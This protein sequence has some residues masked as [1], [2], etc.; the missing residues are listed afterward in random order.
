MRNGYGRTRVWGVVGAVAVL[1]LGGCD[2]PS[3][4]AEPSPK[5]FVFQTQTSIGLVRG[6]TVALQLKRVA[7]SLT[8]PVSLTRDGRHIYSAGDSA[9]TVADTASL[10]EQEIDCGGTCI[11][12]LPPLAPLGDG[13]VG[14]F[15]LVATTNPSQDGKTTTAV[16][17]GIDLNASEHHVENLGSIPLAVP[18]PAQ[19]NVAPY[20]FFLDAAQGVYVFLQAV[21]YRPT[22][23]WELAQTLYI[24]RPGSAPMSLGDYAFPSESDVWGVV[25]PD[26]K[27]LAVGSYSAAESATACSS[28][29]VDLFDTATGERTTIHPDTPAEGEVQYRVRRAWWGA[30][31]SLYVN[32]QQRQCDQNAAWSPPV[33]W[34]YTN[35]RWDRVSTPGPALFALNLGDGETAVVEPKGLNSGI[36]YLI[37][38]GGNRTQIAE[39]VTAIADIRQR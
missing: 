19:S 33:V 1:L 17:K 8:G 39:G 16:V 29:G 32:Y 27:R 12:F 26:R 36:L 30:D 2:K 25:S 5:T 14:G 6:S 24:V 4:P 15:D 7:G 21:V 18:Q 11:G 35:G 9:I 10:V 38:K 13:V 23:P 20:T 34:A 3:R 22:R 37:D 28:V 31:G